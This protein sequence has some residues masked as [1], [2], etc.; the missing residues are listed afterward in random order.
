MI[1][2][3]NLKDDLVKNRLKVCRSCPIYSPTAGGICNGDLWFNPDT[4]D[5]STKPRYG[6]ING[7]GCLLKSKTKLTTAKCPANKW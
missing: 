5:V 7:C 1:D 6:Y 4:G 3:M 2:I